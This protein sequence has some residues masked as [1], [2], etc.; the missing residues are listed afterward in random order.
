MIKVLDTRSSLDE[1]RKSLS[2]ETSIGLVPTMGNLHAGHLTL[3]EKSCMEN[4]FTII[5]IFVN[6]KQFGPTEDFNQYPR[7]FEQDLEKIANLNL[8]LKSKIII[9]APKDPDEIFAKGFSTTISVGA[10]TQ[11]L[12]GRFRPTHFDGVTTVVY[13]LFKLANAHNAYFG[14]KD[15]QQCVIIKK[16]VKDLEIP[17]KLHIMPIIRNSDGLALSSRNQYLND[18]Q[19][20]QALHLPETLIKIEKMINISVD[21]KKLIES[22]L[23]NKAWDYLEVL[24]TKDLTLP[25]SKTKEVVIIGAYRLGSTRLLDNRVVK[26]NA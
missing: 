10:I 9:F 19:K 5:T 21:P 23:E 26:L 14:Q 2:A 8:Q 4:D 11:L 15:F 18:D 17:I 24:D 20:L 22:E 12:C 16:M 3:L 7:T 13:K 25:N 6:P 1:F